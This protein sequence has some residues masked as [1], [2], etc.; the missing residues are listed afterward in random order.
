MKMTSRDRALDKIYKRRD[1]YDIPDWQRTEVWDRPRKQQLIDSILRG[2]R[3]PKFYFVKV[4]DDPEAFEVV[5]GQQRLT[6]VFEFFDNLLPLSAEASRR[7]GGALYRDLK[8]PYSDAFD[9]FEIQF[10]EIEEAEERELK[11]F[12]QRLQVGLPLTA[13]E[14]L[15]SVHSKLTNFTRA[16]ANHP[17]FKQ[18]VAVADK[19]YAHFDVVAKVAAIEVDGIDTGLRFEDLKQLFATNADFSARSNVARRL[20]ET[21]EFLAAAFPA[22]HPMLKNRTVIQSFATLAASIVETGRAQRY[23]ANFLAFFEHFM[24]ELTR[25]VELGQAA[26]DSDYLRF[27]RSIN[28]NVRGGART[29]H[30]ILLR[31]LFAFDPRVLDIFD[32]SAVASSG[33]EAR[34]RQ[35]GE[36]VVDLIGRINSAY[37]A[38]HGSD[39]FKLTNRTSQG[40][41]RLGRKIVNFTDYGTL[42]DDLYFLLHEGPGSR[43]PSPPES[44][45]DVNDLR[46]DLRH[47]VDHGKEKKVRVK[48]RKLGASF[49]KYAGSATPA[50][51]S[52]E[53]FPLV[54]MNVLSAVA[55]DLQ[56][57]FND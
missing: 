22:R 1:R 23:E 50:T 19:R 3:L 28:A 44:F 42:I 46:T 24:A 33:I 40:M 15:N 10:D 13:S 14:K 41:A 45:V 51:L 16:L 18:K 56:T 9:D 35:L 43:L 29:R 32:P 34:I 25:Q 17:F 52:P 39:L 21:F 20:K 57:L 8:Q 27:Q 54:Q 55:T 53:R 36:E 2:W 30:E 31:K 7:Y 37:A 4:A 5:D 47:D 6:T 12:F 11:E 38:K 49:L 48:R 26:T